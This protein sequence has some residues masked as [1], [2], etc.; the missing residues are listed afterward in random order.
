MCTTYDE[1]ANGN[2]VGGNC[3]VLITMV[4]RMVAMATMM[5]I[6]GAGRNVVTPRSFPEKTYKCPINVAHK[7][8]IRWRW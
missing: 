7:L 1:A 5:M 8:A 3:G 2:A 6:R 4:P